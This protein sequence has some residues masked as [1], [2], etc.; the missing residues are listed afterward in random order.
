MNTTKLLTV[1]VPCYNS[2]AFMDHC[3]DTLLTGGDRVEIIIIDDGSKDRTG[4]IADRYAAEHPDIVRVIHQENGGHG[5]GINQGVRHATGRYFKVVDSDDWVDPASFKRVLDKLESLERIGGVDLMICNYVY[6]YQD[7][8]PNQVITY[9]NVFPEGR[10]IGWGDTRHFAINQY[11]TLHSAIYNTQVIRDSAIDLPKHTFFEDNL[12][13]YAP[14]RL[15]KTLCYL[16]ENLYQYLIGREGQ[17]VSDASMKKNYKHQIL[18]ATRIFDA[19]NVS[20]IKRYNPKLGRYMHHEVTMMLA[21]AAAFARINGSEQAER[22]VKEMWDHIKNSGPYGRRLRYASLAGAA[23]IPGKLGRKGCV[24]GF[25]LAH[26][27]VGF[28]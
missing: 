4:E 28:N 16:D 20:A 6:T 12:F 15:T 19:A 21:M 27:I 22:D 13:I 17:S 14:L 1:T 7:G 24:T 10:I 2:E 11:L 9:A 23:S 8:R 3:L 25:R 26:K 18:V 5:E